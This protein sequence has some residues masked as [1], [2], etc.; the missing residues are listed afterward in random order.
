MR[1]S[2]I[3]LWDAVWQGPRGCRGQSRAIGQVL[4]AG[5]VLDAV[6][7][8]RQARQRRTFS[9]SSVVIWLSPSP[10]GHCRSPVATILKPA[11]LRARGGG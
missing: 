9:S 1:R 8:P 3:P 2:W 7:R 10:A 4:A 5:H 11:R 6:P